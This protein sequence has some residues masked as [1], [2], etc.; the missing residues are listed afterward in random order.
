M[1]YSDLVATAAELIAE[2]GQSATV[3]HVASLA[4]DSGLTITVNATGKTFTR[5]Q[6]SWIT[7]GLAIGNSITFAGFASAGNN[8]AKVASNVAA[9]VLTCGA[10]AGLVDEADVYDVTASA[11]QDDA[12]DVLEQDI[13]SIAT[14]AQSLR[15]GSIISDSTRFFMLSGATP[16]VNDKLVIGSASYAIEAVRPLSPGDTAIYYAVRVK[17]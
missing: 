1:D 13:N 4:A 12:C 9:L 15:E 5:N 2:Y 17:A 6:G 10:D 8:G 3:R 16:Q 11:N 7:D 14:Y